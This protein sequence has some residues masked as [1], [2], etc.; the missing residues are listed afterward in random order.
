MH[1]L[2][3]TAQWCASGYDQRQESTKSFVM[4]RISQPTYIQPAV[5]VEGV[6]VALS[7]GF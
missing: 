4:S 5:A 1:S 7:S 2:G 3:M 6:T